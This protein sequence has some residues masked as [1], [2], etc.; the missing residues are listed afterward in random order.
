[1]TSL[2]KQRAEAVKKAEA[3]SGFKE[4]HWRRDD[5]QMVRVEVSFYPDTKWWVWD[6]CRRAGSSNRRPLTK[7]EWVRLGPWL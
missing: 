1:M 4:G 5:G 2:E 7:D 6:F 3:A